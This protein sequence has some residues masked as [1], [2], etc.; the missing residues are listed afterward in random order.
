MGVGGLQWLAPHAQENLGYWGREGH[1]KGDEPGHRTS[2]GKEM[3]ITQ[4]QSRSCTPN[5]QVCQ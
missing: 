5:R 4:T 1:K 2:H 3:Q